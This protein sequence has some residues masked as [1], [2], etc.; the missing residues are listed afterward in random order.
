MEKQYCIAIYP[1][2][3]ILLLVKAMKEK[4]FEEVKW[5]HSKNSVAHITICVFQATEDKIEFITHKLD[6]LCATFEPFEVQL[7]SFDSYSNGAF[8]ISPCEDSKIKLKKIVNK[9]HELLHNLEMQKNSDPHISIA[10]RLTPEKLEK[11]K[12]LFTTINASF[13][14]DSIVLR[15]FNPDLKQFFIT[16]T[17]P[18]N[19]KKNK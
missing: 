13:L 14:C 3:T 7:N 19:T 16:D 2:E 18:F 1:S 17:F 12:H 5:F 10:R 9:V 6:L 15:K 8:F 4:L 11:A